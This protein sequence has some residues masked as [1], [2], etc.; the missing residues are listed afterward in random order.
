MCARA[1]HLSICAIRWSKV[2]RFP[3]VLS[4]A[5]IVFVYY[6]ADTP[7]LIYK[8]TIRGRNHGWKVEGGPR[9]GSQYP[10]RLC[11][12]PGQRPGWCWVRGVASSR[13]EGPG[14]HPRKIFENS[15]AKSRIMVTTCCEISCFLKTTA[16]KLEDQYIV[17]PPT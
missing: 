14:Y 11:P 6:S 1:L 4:R 16:K 17:G 9:F 13:C 15:D 2:L 5:I 3:A 7:N 10:G 12:A 8:Q